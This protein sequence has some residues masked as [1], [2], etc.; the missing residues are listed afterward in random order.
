[1]D[2]GSDDTEERMAARALQPAVLLDSR[3]AD[4]R[5]AER[6]AAGQDND[7]H[8]GDQAA[9]GAAG[10]RLEGGRL[11]PRVK[12]WFAQSKYLHAQLPVCCLSGSAHVSCREDDT[13]MYGAKQGTH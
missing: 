10:S 4:H 11:H 8:G 1:M 6:L 13:V 5:A 12:A 7:R 2:L 3:D 9:T